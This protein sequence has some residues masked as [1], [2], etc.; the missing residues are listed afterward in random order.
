M[1]LIK[2]SLLIVSLA[3]LAACEKAPETAAES[4]PPVASNPAP[5][6]VP[7]VVT[8]A[9][10]AAAPAATAPALPI[11]EVAPPSIPS[12]EKAIDTQA[13]TEIACKT[14]CT[15]MNCPPPI[16][17]KRCCQF[18]SGTYKACL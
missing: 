18:V 1:H 14:G 11:T 6:N 17:P 10:E 9:Q 13:T 8:P 16:G 4:A 5:A 3:L 7:A 2:R 12:V 15:F